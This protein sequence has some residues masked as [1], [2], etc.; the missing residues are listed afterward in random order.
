ME[1]KRRLVLFGLLLILALLCRSSHSLRCYECP[2][3]VLPCTETVTCAS[4]LDACMSASAAAGQHSYFKC[5]KRKDCKSSEI[6]KQLSESNLKYH[7]CETDLC[8]TNLPSSAP[9]T[10]GK[11]FLLVVPLLAAVWN[12]RL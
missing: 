9:V 3:N 10:S 4:D 8:N 6:L 1:S 11:I 7:C 2:K 5:W 12:M